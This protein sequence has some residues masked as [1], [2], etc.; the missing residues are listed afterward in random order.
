MSHDLVSELSGVTI[1]AP[2]S[3]QLE[4]TQLIIH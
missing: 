1:V 2:I 4:T 3:I